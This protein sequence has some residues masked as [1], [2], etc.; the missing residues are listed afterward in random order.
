MALHSA[1]A[2]P[3]PHAAHLPLESTVYRSAE[4]TATTHGIYRLSIPTGGVLDLAIVEAADAPAPIRIQPLRSVCFPGSFS[5]L[6]QSPQSLRLW[7]PDAMDLHLNVAPEDPRFELGDFAVHTFFDPEVEEFPEDRG[8]DP[9]EDDEVS[10]FT[11]GS[12]YLRSP[13]RSVDDDHSDLPSCGSPL[14][15]GEPS[16][17]VIDN[18]W[19]VDADVFTVALD[20]QTT[21]SFDIQGD[22]GIQVILFDAAGQRL[23]T[24]SAGEWF[25]TLGPGH[26]HLRVVGAEPWGA[27]RLWLRGYHP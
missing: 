7:I 3:C 8:T 18:R 12:S 13:C 10:G 19:G 22:P 15:V 27:Y 24:W 14:R 25:R 1:G 6:D 2:Q 16:F 17:G 21:L 20:K 11:T 4:G 9:I 5:I 26:F 23:T